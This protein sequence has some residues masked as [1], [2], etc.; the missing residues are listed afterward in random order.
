MPDAL[1]ESEKAVRGSQRLS[2]A[3]GCPMLWRSGPCNAGNGQ[4]MTIDELNRYLGMEQAQPLHHK[5]QSSSRP[6]VNF[7]YVLRSC[8]NYS[9]QYHSQVRETQMVT[10]AVPCQVQQPTHVAKQDCFA[11]SYSMTKAWTASSPRPQ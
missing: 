2:E 4:R 11:A 6:N 5:P 8:V 10:L 7:V 3:P 9:Q 1:Q